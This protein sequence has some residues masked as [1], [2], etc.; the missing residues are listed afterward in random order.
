MT[1]F[2]ASKILVSACFVFYMSK[3]LMKRE[4]GENPKQTRC[5]KLQKKSYEHYQMPLFLNKI[6]TGRRFNNGVSQKTCQSF[7][8]LTAFGE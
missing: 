2:A 8:S 6:G 3:Q 7:I 5:C 4:L 1:N